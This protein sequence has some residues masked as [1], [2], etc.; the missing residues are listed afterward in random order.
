VPLGRICARPS[1]TVA[2][3]PR[4]QCVCGPR[5]RRRTALDHVGRN[6]CSRRWRGS[7]ARCVRGPRLRG[8]RPSSASAG[9]A[10]G[11]WRGTR[12]AWTL[13]SA[14]SDTAATDRTGRRRLRTAA[15]GTT[16]R[17]ARRGERLSGGTVRRARRSTPRMTGGT[18]SSAF[19]ELKITPD[20]YSSK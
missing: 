8:G 13:A 18:H 15:V 3:G 17:E 11:R 4:A 12:R 1:C 5:P 20:E 14:A 9:A 16:A 2:R 19:S 7:C 10:R 6:L